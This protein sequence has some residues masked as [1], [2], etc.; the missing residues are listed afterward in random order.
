[1]QCSRSRPLGIASV[2]SDRRFHVALF[3]IFGWGNFGNDAT[4]DA[5]MAALH[6]A[7]PRSRI[8]CIA[9]Q[10]ARVALDHGIAAFPLVRGRSFGGFLGRVIGEPV[11]LFHAWRTMRRV[12]TL[13]VAGTGVLDDQH[14]HPYELPLDVL[15]WS[16]A[17][18][19]A[20]ARL[21]FLSV[22]AVP[23]DQRWSRRFLKLAVSLAHEVSYRD[24]RSLDFMRS[25]GSDVGRD[26]VLPDLALALD[27]PE[28]EPRDAST[29]QTVAIGVLARLNW[30]GRDREYDRYENGLVE[31]IEKIAADGRRILIVTGDEADV[32]TQQA[33]VR[34][35]DGSGFTVIARECHSFDDVLEAATECDAM[36]ASRYHNLVAAVVAGIPVVS[37]GYGPKNDAL[38]EQLEMPHWGHDIDSFSV[39]DVHADVL[40][41]MTLPRPLFR[42]TLAAYRESLHAEF[43]RLIDA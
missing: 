1:M 40:E 33:I 41:A 28:A 14:S 24:Q 38:L 13:V 2:K 3:G 19:L 9:A 17:A 10:P 8:A 34:R 23:L 43:E 36:V 26:R 27:P 4:L 18:R 39:D 22:V 7:L 20:R 37:L 11:N 32:G 42:E 29:E 12:R 5:C 31:L 25:I 15:R 30:P 6:P 16:L 35:M 21:V